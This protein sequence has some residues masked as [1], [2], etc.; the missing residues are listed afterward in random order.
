MPSFTSIVSVL[1]ASASA[2]AFTTPTSFNVSS[3]PIFTPASAQIVPVGTPFKITWKPTESGTVSIV[4]LR[5]PSTNV[6]PLYAIAEKIPNSGSF[7]WTPKSDLEAD[8]THYGL[9]LIKDSD[10]Q[11]QY[12]VQFGISNPNYKPS[13]SSSSASSVA[14]TS[15]P[16]GYGG[17]T[18]S[19]TVVISHT[20]HTSVTSLVTLTTSAPVYTNKTT[21]TTEKPLTTY[22]PIP[23]HNGT[24]TTGTSSPTYSNTQLP[25]PS[26]TGAASGLKVA[27]GLLVAVAGAVAILL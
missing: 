19:S 2:F 7:E 10:G 27:S 13:S 23:V 5:G 9:E 12:S 4:L 11:F 22:A 1:A 25:S 21:T 18:T 16:A 20:V 17:S 14:T 3:N 8:T 15:T 24:T 26:Q 6:Q